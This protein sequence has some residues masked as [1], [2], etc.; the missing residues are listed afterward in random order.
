MDFRVIIS[1]PQS[2]NAYQVEAKDAAANKFLGHKISDSIDGEAVGMP[3]YTLQITGGSDREGFPMR[4][5]IPG[6][7]RR[8]VLISGGVGY[9]SEEAGCR[10]RKSVRGCDIASDVGQINLKIVERGI[11]PVEE[12]LGITSLEEDS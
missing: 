6:T 10:R 12:L 3:G 7:K 1:D 8:K 11:K 9:H 2:G 5:D 4:R